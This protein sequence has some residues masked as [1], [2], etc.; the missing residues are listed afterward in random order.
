MTVSAVL[1]RL[2][3]PA[4]TGAAVPMAEEKGDANCAGRSGAESSTPLKMS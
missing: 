1:R 3:T 2:M 4:K